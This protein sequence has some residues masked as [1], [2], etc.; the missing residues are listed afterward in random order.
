MEKR[1]TADV[2]R[3][4]M[5]SIFLKLLEYHQGV[6]FLTSNRVKEIDEAF[7]R[8]LTRHELNG[9]QI[10]STIRMAQALAYYEQKPMAKRHMEVTIKN[11]LQ[12][13]QDMKMLKN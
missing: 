13:E 2:V 10:R 9:R 7:Y 12:F 4:A 8:L 3:N 5:V 1:A 6:L 11:T